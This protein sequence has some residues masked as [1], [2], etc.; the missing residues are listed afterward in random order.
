MCGCFKENRLNHLKQKQLF[1]ES[2][3]AFTEVQEN[4][5]NHLNPKPLYSVRV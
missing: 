2:L 4:G 3:A 5:L 1:D